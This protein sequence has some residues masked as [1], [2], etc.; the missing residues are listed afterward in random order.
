METAPAGTIAMH[1][2]DAD[3]RCEACM[4]AKRESM[5]GP[6]GGIMGP[7]GMSR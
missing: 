1:H 7:K 6:K 2:G 5:R 3:D 4:Q